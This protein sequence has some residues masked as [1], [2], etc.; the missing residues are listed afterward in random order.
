M[1]CIKPCYTP[2][3]APPQYQSPTDTSSFEEEEE[4]PQ[5]LNEI[6]R[7]EKTRKVSCCQIPFIRGKGFAYLPSVSI[8]T[9][10]F[11]KPDLILNPCLKIMF[12]NQWSDYRSKYEAIW[13]ENGNEW[14]QETLMNADWDICETV[15][16]F[17]ELQ[18]I[19]YYNQ[20]VV[21]AARKS[22]EDAEKNAIEGLGELSSEVPSENDVFDMY[23]N[24]GLFDPPPPP[25]KKEEVSKSALEKDGYRQLR[26]RIV[27][28]NS[29][30][31]NTLEEIENMANPDEE[32]VNS[33]GQTMTVQRHGRELERAKEINI[34]KVLNFS[35][36]GLKDYY[37]DNLLRSIWAGCIFCEVKGTTLCILNKKRLSKISKVSNSAMDK[38]LGKY[39][40]KTTKNVTRETLDKYLGQW[41][42]IPK[43]WVI[44]ETSYKPI[45]L[46]LVQ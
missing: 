7:E 36:G 6:F 30:S 26:E 44:Y 41:N 1:S 27:G 28:R 37:M 33:D 45:P 39:F 21:D 32:T 5:A 25:P 2:R 8:F 17:K 35:Q 4:A 43:K 38:F 13:Q 29:L 20:D 19:G 34:R 9:F 22:E 23:K 24:I 46:C 31:K 12:D 40:V 15:V 16:D 10:P 42:M 11:T 18:M 14:T 3:F